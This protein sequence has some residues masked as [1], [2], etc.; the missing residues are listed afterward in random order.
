MKL[1]E[2]MRYRIL[3]YI[4]GINLISMILYHFIWDMV[5]IFG[6][7][8]TW[9]KSEAGYIWQQSICWTFIMLSGF[10]W[11]LGKQRLKRGLTVL[12]AG[13]LVT[14]IT[15]LVMPENQIIFGVLSL[16]GSCT[17]LLIPLEKIL[18]KI[19]KGIGFLSCMV[20]FILLR[21]INEGYIGIGEDILFQLPEVLYQGYLMTY[22]GFT[23]GSFY[24]TDYFSIFPWVFLFMAGYF[25]YGMM[26]KKAL[27]KQLQIERVTFVEMMGKHSLMLY[28]MHQPIIYLVLN[29]WS[30][31]N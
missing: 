11:S 6:V 13:M 10:C 16:M 19:P 30:E 21:H 26:Q 2:S 1:G 17:L 20:I 29:I 18:K 9:Y 25:L 12:G 22:L 7:N 3:D 24:S 31:V 23:D 5:Y 28:L 8:W 27:L 15:V 14:A 4:R